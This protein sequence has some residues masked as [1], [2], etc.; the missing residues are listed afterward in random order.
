VHSGVVSYCPAMT[1]QEK[2]LKGSFDLVP[3]QFVP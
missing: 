1:Q 3:R 2:K